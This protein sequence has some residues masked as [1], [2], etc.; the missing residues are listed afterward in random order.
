MP[1]MGTKESWCI[2]TFCLLCRHGLI[3]SFDRKLSISKCIFCSPVAW[4]KVVYLVDKHQIYANLFF[5]LL[6][7][8]NC[9]GSWF[10]PKTQMKEEAD[11]SHRPVLKS[12]FTILLLWC[13]QE[14]NECACFPAS[15]QSGR[16]SLICVTA[17]FFHSVSPWMDVASMLQRILQNLLSHS[18]KLSRMQ[19]CEGRTVWRITLN[20]FSSI[21]FK[22]NFMGFYFSLLVYWIDVLLL[23]IV[24]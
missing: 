10:G 12:Q 7:F 20:M 17:L 1:A 9:L 18:E 24:S 23:S 21:I 14:E 8:D 15:A 6:E 5:A 4:I 3:S 2:S 22:L 16:M 19:M 11:K 13:F